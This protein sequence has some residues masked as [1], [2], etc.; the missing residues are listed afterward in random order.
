VSDPRWTDET[1]ALAVAIHDAVCHGRTCPAAVI[2]TVYGTSATA[3]LNHLASRGLL[4][5]PG[6]ETHEER[7]Y[8][9]PDT[10]EVQSWWSY[11]DHGY[12]APDRRRTV[13]TW[14]DGSWHYGPWQPATQ[15]APHA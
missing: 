6:G 15:E 10:R 4:V 5:Q 2:A 7:G 14:P 11:H 13:T 1:Y 8:W 12:K 9:N 3:A